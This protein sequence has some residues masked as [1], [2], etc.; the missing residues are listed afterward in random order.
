MEENNQ[1]KK[2]TKC[3][4]ND[5]L[6]AKQIKKPSVRLQGTISGG[7]MLVLSHKHHK[8]D[9]FFNRGADFYL[10]VALNFMETIFSD[11]LFLCYN[12]M[13]INN[14][15]SYIAKKTKSILRKNKKRIWH[16]L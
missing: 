7:I 14:G 16:N 8:V 13:T 11:P 6:K 3:L 1:F 12:F 9:A 4:L 10:K 2:R 15:L 5:I